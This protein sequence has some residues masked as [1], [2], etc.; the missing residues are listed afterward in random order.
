M[1]DPSPTF[2]WIIGAYAASPTRWG[3]DVN[4][5]CRFLD[6]V[7]ELPGVSGLEVPFTGEL[8]KYDEAWFLSWLPAHLDVVLTLIPGTTA[9]LK[10]DPHFGLASDNDAGRRAAVDF[11]EQARVSI[12]RINDHAG[13]A[14]VRAVQI[15]T[16]PGPGSGSARSL[17]TSLQEL[18]GRTWDGAALVIEHCDAPVPGRTPAKG[19]MS[20]QDEIAAVEASGGSDAGLGLCV[21]W[22]R[23]AIETQSVDGPVEHINAAQTAGLLL[24]VMFSGATDVDCAFGSAWADVHV[25]P[26]PTDD[27]SGGRMLLEPTSLMTVAQMRRC[28]DAAGSAVSD[29]YVG[30]KIAPL[31]DVTVEER[32]Q[33]VAWSLNLLSDSAQPRP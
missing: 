18:A 12:G 33:T 19:Y 30:L 6:G 1:T 24:G 7:V 22:G 27:G 20:L 17:Q 29:G 10:D 28:L 2:N 26:A 16:A 5:E 9:R 31:K 32:I 13:R 4:D 11:V 14:A 8:H 21:N 3:W 25:P 23:S 15:H